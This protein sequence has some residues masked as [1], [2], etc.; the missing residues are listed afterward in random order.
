MKSRTKIGLALAA[1]LASASAAAP[2]DAGDGRLRAFI[3]NARCYA[4]LPRRAHKPD[5]RLARV[6]DWKYRKDHFWI[7]D[8]RQR[9]GLL[10]L[11]IGE[12]EIFRFFPPPGATVDYRMPAVHHWATLQGPRITI[13]PQGSWTN[14]GAM[15]QLV[16]E[17]LWMPVWTAGA[18]RRP[19][20]GGETLRLRYTENL[21]GRTEMVHDFALRF[22]PVL[23]YVLDCEFDLR[24]DGPRCFEYTN[25]LTGGLSDSRD[26]RKRYQKCVWIRR[27]GALCYMYQN[28]RSMMQSSGPEWTDLPDD[29]GFVGWVAERD[30][31]PFLEIV[32]SAPR[33]T[34]VTC[35]QWYDQHVFNLPPPRREDDGLY[36]VTASYRM[37]SL[38]LP[39]A[40]ELEDA[41][42]TMLPLPADRG[43]AP[44]GFRQHVVNDFETPIPAG[45]LYNGSMWGH[46]ARLETGLG[47]SGSRSLRVDGGQE[48]QP[49]HGGTAVYLE[50]GK[51]YRLSAWVR[52]RGVTGGA[53]LR[54]NQVFWS[55]EDVRA[56][57]R[58]KGLT[59]DNDWTRLEIEFTPIAGDP[60]AAPG[61]VVEGRGT[62][63]F[64]DVELVEVP[65]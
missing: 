15:A 4:S 13:V 26:R 49:V 36:H 17:T 33:G 5:F 14:R 61:L 3:A 39:L 25:L 64:D 45:T 9:I 37:L 51:R 52:T 65:R 42:R 28:P 12:I 54:A 46:A 63:W 20:P 11:W 38:P 59:G 10:N 50:T 56:S 57:L 47:R 6:R 58:S 34:L 19:P 62:A 2:E 53:Y 23:G 27:D 18:L 29:G 48:A 55:W 30:M 40:K 35:S 16:G 8:G 44:M 31:N 21:G 32:R 1:V 22:D 24:A 60:F 43:A 7:M 41:A